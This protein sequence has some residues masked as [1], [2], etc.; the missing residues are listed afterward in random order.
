MDLGQVADIHGDR[1]CF[2]MD[3]KESSQQTACA[4]GASDESG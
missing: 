4:H 3:K 1:T 2:R